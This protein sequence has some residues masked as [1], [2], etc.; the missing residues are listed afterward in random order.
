MRE[1]VSLLRADLERRSLRK[2][3]TPLSALHSGSRSCEH[4]QDET[5]QQDTEESGNGFQ[6]HKARPTPAVLRIK[7]FFEGPVPCGLAR[8]CNLASL[9][10]QVEQLMTIPVVKLRVF[11]KRVDLN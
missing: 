5:P 8:R 7:F 10:C 9:R 3:K 2:P 1:T 6:K 11:K 4:Q